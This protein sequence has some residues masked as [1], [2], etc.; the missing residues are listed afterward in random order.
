MGCQAN[1]GLNER[2]GVAMV[3]QDVKPL[4]ATLASCTTGLIP[5]LAVP[6]P[7]QHPADVPR[8][9]TEVA[10]VLGSLPPGP[11]LLVRLVWLSGE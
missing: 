1:W 11:R 4:L 3:V 7:F 6:P 10:Q 9:A 5:V 2:P 8:E